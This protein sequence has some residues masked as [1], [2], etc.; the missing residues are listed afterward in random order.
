M[1]VV[2]TDSVGDTTWSRTYRASLLSISEG[3]SVIAVR[4]G[5]FVAFGFSTPGNFDSR[6]FYLVRLTEDGDTLWTRTYGGSDVPDE[7]AAISETEDGGFVLVGNTS[8]SGSA[9][10]APRVIRISANGSVIWERVF[11]RSCSRH[12]WISDVISRPEG[13]WIIAG[14]IESASQ[15]GNDYFLMGI[16]NVG[17]SLWS[18]TYPTGGDGTISRMLHA[19]GGGYVLCGTVLG[20]GFTRHHVLIVRLSNENLAHPYPYIPVES[21]VLAVYPNPF[22]SMANVMLTTRR[23][24]LVTL[25]IY[26]LLGRCVAHLYRGQVGAGTHQFPFSGA[27]LSSGTYICRALVPGPEHSIAHAVLLIR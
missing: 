21:D 2:K 15:N 3:T 11:S 23:A 4:E 19:D 14:G 13:G 17:D 16:N 12:P 6:D 18:A 9:L 20:G 10:C 26:D 25:D 27:P 7:S 5:G 22:N 8:V 1:Y 24:G